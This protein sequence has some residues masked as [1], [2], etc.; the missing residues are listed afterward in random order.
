MQKAVLH[1]QSQ[2]HKFPNDI[3]I[4]V[5]LIFCEITEIYHR[6]KIRIKVDKDFI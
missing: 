5:I 6:N 4:D 1:N 3:C 2:Y